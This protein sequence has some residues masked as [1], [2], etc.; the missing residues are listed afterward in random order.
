MKQLRAK[1]GVVAWIELQ[2]SFPIIG[3]ITRRYLSGGRRPAVLT[4]HALRSATPTAASARRPNRIRARQIRNLPS[5]GWVLT[6]DLPKRREVDRKSV[7]QGKR[8]DIR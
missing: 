3:W 4:V 1:L 5:N 6:V 7:V 2:P 8:R